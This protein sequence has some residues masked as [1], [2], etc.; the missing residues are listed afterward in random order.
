MQWLGCNS[1]C[2][3]STSSPNRLSFGQIRLMC[4]LFKKVTAV[5]VSVFIS[6]RWA[7][8]SQAGRC[9]HRWSAPRWSPACRSWWK[10][11]DLWLRSGR[12]RPAVLLHMLDSAVA[13]LA[14]LPLWLSV[15]SQLCSARSSAAPR[16]QKDKRRK[17]FLSYWFVSGASIHT[18]TCSF[19]HI[20]SRFVK[21]S[22]FTKKG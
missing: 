5:H 21:W 11:R 22:L 8:R 13:G 16:E 3:D 6:W 7:S 2:Y 4:M 9:L 12:E 19:T 17:E 15:W 14:H 20:V 18:N 1:F 10:K